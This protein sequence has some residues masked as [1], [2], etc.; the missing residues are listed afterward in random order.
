[1][2]VSLNIEDRLVAA[3]LIPPNEVKMVS[4]DTTFSA[5]LDHG[6][7]PWY[8][9]SNDILGNSGKSTMQPLKDFIQGKE[10]KD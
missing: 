7:D 5:Q 2:F 4:E 1:M 3:A 6:E 10:I 8:V 9:K